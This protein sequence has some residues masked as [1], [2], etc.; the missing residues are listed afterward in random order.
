MSGD[1]LGP[2]QLILATV[3]FGKYAYDEIRDGFKSANASVFREKFREKYTDIPLE[4]SYRDAI[5]D[6]ANYEA[7]WERIEQYKAE[8][9]KMALFYENTPETWWK[10]V[11]GKRLKIFTD[12][13]KLRSDDGYENL[14]MRDN[15]DIVANLLMN[16]HGKYTY[17]LT[18]SE[19]FRWWPRPDW[20]WID[21]HPAAYAQ[22][23]K[24][25]E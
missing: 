4:K 23:K 9:G 2:F 11:G 13:G 22:P 15:R 19:V 14:R 24:K 18:S 25:I 17:K 20:S 12:D 10:N 16:T 1:L 8:G 21:V 7:L 5:R 3:G 6:P